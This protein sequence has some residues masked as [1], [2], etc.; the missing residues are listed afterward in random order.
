VDVRKEWPSFRTL[1]DLMEHID[2]EA[3]KRAERLAAKYRKMVEITPY[4]QVIL[5]LLKE[6]KEPLS[7]DLISF[8]TGISKSRC[9]KILRKLEEKW[10]LVKKVTV[11]QVAYY[12]A[13]S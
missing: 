12:T 11:A 8:L 4:D 2:T 7:I 1:E 10:G 13:T 5:N 3:R 6:V 9:C